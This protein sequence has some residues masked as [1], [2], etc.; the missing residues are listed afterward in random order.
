[1][2]LGASLLGRPGLVHAAAPG[3]W[4]TGKPIPIGANEVV[5]AAA[6]G[7]MFVYGGLSAFVPQGLFFMYDP[8]T[9]DWTT[10][11]SHPQ[12]THH[13]AAVGV[14]NRFYVF[15]GF[16]KPAS[17]PPSWAPTNR[18]WMFDLD[19]RR[20]TELAPMPTARGAL[21]ASE[22]GGRVYVIGGSIV[23]KWS[24]QPGLTL[25][26]GGEQSNV[27]E[28]FDLATGRWSVAN[29]MLQG[30]NHMESGTIDGKIYVVGG[31]VGSAFVGAATNISDNEAYDV[32]ADTW[33]PAALMPTPRSGVECAVLNGRLHVLGGEGYAAGLQG[34]SNYHEVYDP[35]SNS[36]AIYPPMPSR[37]HGF[38]IGVIDGRI[39]AITGSDV[40]GNGGGVATGIQANEV[41]VPE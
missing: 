16:E 18:T 21:T 39:Y 15:G 2:G 12:P 7:K 23:P 13:A 38:A 17:G 32:A 41:W 25:T 1:M 26:W 5:G 40:A 27:N 31:R 37:R 10:L 36:W 8:V 28:V 3:H 11:P 22:A 4:T 6:G 24:K 34:T 20:W 14:G 29:P 9:D 35:K 30:R 33:S 19:D